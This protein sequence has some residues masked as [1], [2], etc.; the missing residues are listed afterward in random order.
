M[1]YE[2]VIGETASLAK[3][4]WLIN[5]PNLVKAVEKAERMRKSDPQFN[6]LWV[7]VSAKEVGKLQ[8]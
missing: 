1:I 5:S 3:E 4:I 6:G 8:S 7:I 2:I